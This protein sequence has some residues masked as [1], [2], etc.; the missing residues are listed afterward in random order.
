VVKGEGYFRRSC[1][2][3]DAFR[4]IRSKEEGH[5]QLTYEGTRSMASSARLVVA[6]LNQVEAANY[7][8]DRFWSDGKTST[9]TSSLLLQA[10]YTNHNSNIPN[11]RFTDTSVVMGTTLSF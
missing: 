8:E 1:A 5:R 6:W 7:L 3:P 9:R 2:T 4:G 10:Q 11:F